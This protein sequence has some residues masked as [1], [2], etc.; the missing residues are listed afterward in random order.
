MKKLLIMLLITAMSISGCSGN[1][2]STA[3]AVS[4]S[5]TQD[6]PFGLYDTEVSRGI[7]QA[8]YGWGID[9]YDSNT[10]AIELDDEELILEMSFDNLSVT[11]NVGLVFII[12]GIIQSYTVDGEEAYVNSIQLEEKTQQKVSYTIHPK[13]GKDGNEHELLIGCIYEPNAKCDDVNN[14]FDG[15]HRMNTS[16]PWKI[17][18]SVDASEIDEKLV[19]KSNSKQYSDINE[20]LVKRDDFLYDDESSSDVVEDVSKLDLVVTNE[21]YGSY[22]LIYLLN[23]YPIKTEEIVIEDG[24][25]YS[26]N[27]EFLKNF[28]YGDYSN[29]SVILC[30]YEN[31][32]YNDDFMLDIS[33]TISIKKGTK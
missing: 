3:N 26:Q 33:R 29:L 32:S 4:D 25:M 13:Y 20:D 15:T 22:R 17:I 24:K 12:D 23:N 21:E 9:N 8:N 5:E 31:G 1:N 2:Q 10:R 14:I 28:E 6:N 7:I 11:C 18:H 27:M 30:P 16:L 19:E